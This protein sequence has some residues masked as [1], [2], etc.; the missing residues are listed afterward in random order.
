[1]YM[2]SVLCMECVCRCVCTLVCAH[3]MDRKG[4]RHGSRQSHSHCSAPSQVLRTSTPVAFPV[5]CPVPS[6]PVGILGSMT[7]EMS[8]ESCGGGSTAQ[9]AG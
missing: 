8:P 2:C 3:S 7:W 9:Q 6:S 5:F 1:M 4:D